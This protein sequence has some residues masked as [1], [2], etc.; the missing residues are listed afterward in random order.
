[1]RMSRSSSTAERAVDALKKML[2]NLEIRHG[3]IYGY[4]LPES[5]RDCSQIESSLHRNPEALR[6]GMILT[7]VLVSGSI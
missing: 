3:H 5:R 1:M 6:L 4:S 2:P 7:G